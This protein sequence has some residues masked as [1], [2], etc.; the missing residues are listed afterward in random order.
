[1][2]YEK[3]YKEALE[4]AKQVYKTPYTAHWDVMKELIEHLF[5]ELKESQDERI[6]KMLIYQMERWH[7]AALE[8]NAV[9]DIKDSADAITW[10]EKQSEKKPNYCHHEVDLSDCS[11]EYRKAYY[12]GWNNCNQQHEQLKAEQKPAWSEKDEKLL[13]LSLENLTELKNRF[14]EEYG[15][16]GDCINWLK[17]LKDRVGCEADCTTTKEWSEEDEAMFRGVIE[18]EQYILDV[19]YGRKIFAVGNESIKEECTK[20]LSWLKSLRPKKQWKPS[21]EQLRELENVFSPDTDSWDEGVL[22]KLYEQ[23]KRL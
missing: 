9:Q 6:R 15:K 5:P 18:T 2:N 12:D 16:V 11:E 1:M 23:L 10:L 17:S 7:E 19:V 22:R 13:K 3:K 4:R 20:E 14:D 21:E 8:N